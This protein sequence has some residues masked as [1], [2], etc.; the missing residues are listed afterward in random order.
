MIRSAAKNSGFTLIELVLIIV[1]LGIIG[2]IALRSMQP[3]L[4]R[5]RADA[6]MKEMME[7]EYAIIGNPD[8]ISD[9]ARTDFGYV[10]DVGSLPPDLD[11]LATNTGSYSTWKGPY[12]RGDFVENPDDFKKD[13]WGDLYAYAGGISILSNGGGTVMTRNFAQAAAELTSNTVRGSIFDGLGS[14]PGGNN[15]DIAVTIIFPDGNGSMASLSVIPGLDGS[16]SFDNAIPI[17]NHLLRGVYSITNDTT[18]RYVSVAPGSTA[19][20][21]LRFPGGLW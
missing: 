6:T 5:A 12:V 19:Y 21:E 9:A 1:I 7:L 17:G 11:A 10:G 13:A 4:E 18:A 20:G 15:S 3:V 16:F 2:S 14:I 8:L